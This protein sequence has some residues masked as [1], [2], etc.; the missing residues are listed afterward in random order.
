MRVWILQ[1]GEPLHIDKGNPRPMRAINL[2]DK[3]VSAGH[4]VVLWSSSFNH[5]KKIHRSVGYRAYNVNNNLEIRLIPSRGYK[6]HIGFGRLTDHAQMAWNLSKLLK[7]EK[8]IPD[9]AFIG[10]PPIETAA[11]MS[12]WLKKRG[13]PTLLDVKDLWP[14]IIVDSFPRALQP[15]ARILLH[16]YFYLAKKTMT[17]VSGISTMSNSFLNWSLSFANKLPSESDKIVRLTTLNIKS[18]EEKLNSANQWWKENNVN[19]NTDTPRVF[20]TGTFS[21]AFDFDQIRIAAEEIIDCQFVLCGH[22]PCLDETKK[23]MK[24]LPNVVFPG[25]I[26]RLQMESLSNMSIASLAPYKN[27]DNFTLNIPN[28]VVDSFSLGSPILSPLKGEVATLIENNAVGFTY[29]SDRLLSDCI[30][31]LLDD[32]ELQKQMSINAKKLYRREFEFNKVYDSL[33]FHLE[34][35]ANIN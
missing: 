32:N 2:S 24:G 22:G 35:L 14:S 33:V 13:V 28:K 16:P 7:Q 10:Y 18:N 26:D 27:I 25:W 11:V 4:H 9:V 3:L 21:T 6:N 12:R 8:T 34:K 30:Q 19:S 20:F 29:D 1:T 15:F 17:D 31:S 23:L 5:Q